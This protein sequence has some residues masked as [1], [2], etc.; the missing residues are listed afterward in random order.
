[1]RFRRSVRPD[2]FGETAP[3]AYREPVVLTRSAGIVERVI[4]L[5]AGIL[6]VLLA[7]RFVLSLLGANV[8]NPFA[9][10][11]YS[12]TNPLVTPFATL[13]NFTPS[14]GIGYFDWPAI[15]AMV[16]ISVVAWIIISLTRVDRPAI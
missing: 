7:I 9:S 11:I 5:I 10:F 12:L 8:A 13:F 15:V 1:M 2:E 14:T 16:V 6:N 3:V 4:S